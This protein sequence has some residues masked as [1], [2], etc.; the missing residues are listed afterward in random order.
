MTFTGAKANGSNLDGFSPTEIV[1]TKSSSSTVRAQPGTISGGS[2][3]DT[4]KAS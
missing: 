2:F 1:M 3:A 4:W